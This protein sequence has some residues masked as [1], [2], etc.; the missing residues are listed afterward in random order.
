MYKSDD[1]RPYLYK[2]SDYGKTW[3]RIVNGIP[4]NAF[5]RVIREDPNRKGCSW[6]ARSTG[7]SSRSTTAR[8]GGRSR[9][10]CRSRSIT[11]VVFQKRENELVVA[12]QGRSFYVFDDMP[13]LHQLNGATVDGGRAPFQAEGRVP[14]WRGRSWR[15]RGPRR[16]ATV[17]ANP[18]GR[19]GGVLRAEGGGEGSEARVPRQRG[20]G[21]QYVFESGPGAGSAGP[22]RRGDDGPPPRAPA[23][24]ATAAAGMN[25]FVWN[26]RYPD[27]TSFPGMILWAASVTGPRVV[28]GRVPGP[29]DG[30]WQGADAVV[31][32][33][34]GPAH[35]DH[36]GGIRQA[37]L[38]GAPNPRQ[39]LG[40]ATRASC[41]FARRRSS[42]RTT[43][44]ATT[45]ASRTP[46]R[47]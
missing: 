45:S 12:T 17:G 40:D 46:P 25:R 47:R 8:T 19:R 16:A 13:L 42:S 9:T 4:A 34:E 24:R 37:A 43:R 3:K 41:G 1:F 5:T 10:I 14:L 38:A 32:S 31:R 18:R 23:A 30:G 33:E 20:E 36:A 7:C 26:L 35:R 15:R 22:W 27:A 2:T 6:R 44:S 39:A 21:R 28:A 29:A 11:D